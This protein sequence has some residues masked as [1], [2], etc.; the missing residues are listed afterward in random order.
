MMT[1]SRSCGLPRRRF[2]AMRCSRCGG[3]VSAPRV[4]RPQLHPTTGPRT[5]TNHGGGFRNTV[6]RRTLNSTM[7]IATRALASTGSQVCRRGS[8]RSCRR[9]PG[10]R[11]SRHRLDAS[12][13]PCPSDRS[14]RPPPR[15]WLVW[16]RPRPCPRALFSRCP[17]RRRCRRAASGWNHWRR[18]RRCGAAVSA[19]SSPGKLPPRPLSPRIS[20]CRSWR[21]GR[22]PAAVAGTSETD[23][24]HRW[25][26]EGSCCAKTA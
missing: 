25:G 14:R 16:P 7:W 11:R 21:R 17:R 22:R 2:L 9:W 3:L 5:L 26:F 15:C 13:T 8:R 24:Q 20:S 23:A 4:R 12:R 6:R 10:R 18:P 1:A 19:R